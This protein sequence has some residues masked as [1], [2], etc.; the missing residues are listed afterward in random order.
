MTAV[1][2]HRG[3]PDLA[4]GIAEN[5]IAAFQRARE[6]GAH[7]VELDVRLTADGGIAVTHDPEL[8]GLGPVAELR[9]A[10]L[11]DE[12]P[13]LAAVLEA[14]EGLSVNVEVKNLPTEPGF[15]PDD[16][17]ARAVADLAA[18]LPP[19]REVVVSSFWPGALEAV[20]DRQPA[21]ATGLLLARRLPTDV[22]VAAALERGC[23]ALHPA[24]DLVTAD[25]VD[26]AHAAG[27][28]VAAWT[29]NH[30]DELAAARVLGVD[31]VITDDVPTALAVLGDG[32]R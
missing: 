20:R 19:G 28:A 14:T 27:L 9:A 5:T 10:D 22:A 32:G 11:P 13:L 3:S 18:A 6:L 4:S 1:V 25:L 23:S 12:V 8:P 21:V 17:L 2:A 31:T 7:G 15:D 30:R 26:A 16:R 24:T 29:V